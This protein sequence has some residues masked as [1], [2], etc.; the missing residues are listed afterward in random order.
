MHRSGTSALARALSIYGLRL[1]A[2]LMLPQADNPRGFFEPRGVVE[3]NNR[4]LAA[5]GGSWDR[6]GPFLL[7]NLDVRQSL[8]QISELIHTGWLQEAVARIRRAY[9]SDG[10][11]VL[12]DPRIGFF[13][14]LWRSALEEAGFRPWFVLIHR[15]PLEVA[16]SLHARNGL[17]GRRALQIWQCLHWHVFELERAGGLDAVVSYEALLEAP[18]D[19]LQVLVQGLGRREGVTGEEATELAGHISRE[20]HHH[21]VSAEEVAKRAPPLV[22]ETWA[23]LRAW[24]AAG[25]DDRRREIDGLQRRFEEAAV[26]SGPAVGVS[27]QVL[28]TL[29]APGAAKE[30]GTGK[31]EVGPA[32]AIPAAGAPPDRPAGAAV[33]KPLIL[34][35]H[36][37]KNAGTSVDAMLQ[38]NFGDAWASTEFEIGPGAPSNVAEVE[39]YLR[40]RPELAALSSHTA[41]L[42]LPRLEGR[43]VFPI[44][45]IR[46][47]LDR[48]R[49]AYEFERR[50]TKDTPGSLLARKYDFAGYLRALLEQRGQRQARNFQTARLARGAT[51]GTG[52]ERERALITLVGLPFVGLV[53]AYEA[54]LER[55][56]AA[57]SPR[58]PGFQAVAVRHNVT[59]AP[60]GGDLERRLREMEAELGADL[61]GELCAANEDDL[62]IHAAVRTRY[63]E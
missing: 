8:A 57:L 15:N 61:F 35:Y 24:G 19:A 32:E 46:H 40:A 18:A 20:A 29:T 50:Q 37:F 21:S 5:L 4:I 43:S 58:V 16:A 52:S 63:A 45:F 14:P 2:D 49:S 7:P 42:P 23:L 33:A 1:P 22:A 12:K 17:G 11:V 44:I 28:H 38:R 31:G 47:P 59:R 53:D 56:Q 26:F 39:A 3:L 34:H 10:P 41:L 60:G 30:A 54:S 25:A 9:G 27:M 48:L 55:L 13:L 6:P 36:L 62:A 51:A